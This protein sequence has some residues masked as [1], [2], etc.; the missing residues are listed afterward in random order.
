MKQIVI[1]VSYRDGRGGL[2]MRRV[3]LDGSVHLDQL[4]AVCS[5]A[6]DLQHDMKDMVVVAVRYDVRAQ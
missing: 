6:L 5:Q 3:L 4:P 1:D 2:D